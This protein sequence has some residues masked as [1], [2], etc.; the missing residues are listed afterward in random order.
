[1]DSGKQAKNEGADMADKST[2]PPL[3]QKRLANSNAPKK[4]FLSWNGNSRNWESTL[5]IK[6]SNLRISDDNIITEH[7][8]FDT[9][10][11]VAFERDLPGQLLLKWVYPG[12]I[13]TRSRSN[14][15]GSLSTSGV[16]VT[17]YGTQYRSE[18]GRGAA[19]TET[20]KRQHR[21]WITPI[22]IRASRAWEV[23]DKRLN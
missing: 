6:L 21:L 5:L 20:A 13:A 1:M 10:T 4:R 8:D 22:I 9:S 23:A 11:K 19:S 16:S 7:I 2:R 17:G 15:S 3:T 18:E 14:G 12:A